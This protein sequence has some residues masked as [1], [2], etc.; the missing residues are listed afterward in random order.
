MENAATLADRAVALAEAHAHAGEMLTRCLVR[1]SALALRMH[2]LEAAIS[3]ASRAVA[4][5]IARTDPSSPSSY[6][7]RAYAVLGRALAAGGRSD[8][9]RATLTS[10][11]QHFEATL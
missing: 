7:G 11:L 8:E 1:R 10:A 2:R 9:A 4:I 5:E 6:T 3:D